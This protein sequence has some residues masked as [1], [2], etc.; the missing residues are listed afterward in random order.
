[1]VGTLPHSRGDI[2]PSILITNNP[3][4]AWLT[5][6]QMMQIYDTIAIIAPIIGI[7]FA[8]MNDKSTW[9]VEFASTATDEQRAAAQAVI[10]KLDVASILD[11]EPLKALS[12]RQFY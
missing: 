10:D 4:Q 6:S 5:P 8:D 3:T 2:S 12:R 11:I 7:S 9:K 1:M